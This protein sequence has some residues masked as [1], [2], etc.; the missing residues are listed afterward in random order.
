MNEWYLMPA[1]RYV[2]LDPVRAKLSGDPADFRWSS[3]RAHLSGQDDASVKA[4]PLL[5]LVPDWRALLES[6]MDERETKLLRRDER[7]G[8]PL[9]GETFLKQVEPSVGCILRRGK[10]VSEMRAERDLSVV[11]PELGLVAMNSYLSTDAVIA[12]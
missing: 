1:A 3:A 2:D 4:A 5:G 11:S 12:R 9:G 6:R 10:G 8:R 7:I